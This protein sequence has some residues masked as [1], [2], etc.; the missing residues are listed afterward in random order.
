M[1]EKPIPPN[2]WRTIVENVPIVSVDLVVKHDGGILLGM[3][4][5][6]PAKG[7]WFVPGGTVL[8]GES[9]TDAVHRVATEE[10]GVDVTINDRLG[11][12]EHFYDTSEVDGI[13]SKHYVATA[14]VVTPDTNKLNTD[15]Q[16]SRFQVF[17]PPYETVHPYVERYL[18]K[19]D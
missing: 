8:K 17:E 14:F 1:C 18:E 13:D 3:R 6:E 2:E 4:E 10:L 15:T 16:H 11:T 7:E 5:N 19:L 9:L 12:F